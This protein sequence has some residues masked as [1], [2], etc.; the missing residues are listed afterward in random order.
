MSKHDATRPTT[1]ADIVAELRR[2]RRRLRVWLVVD[3]LAR[4]ALVTIAFFVCAAAADY[5]LGLPPFLRGGLVIAA[6][7][8]GFTWLRR[9]LL[10]P[11]FGTIGLDEIAVRLGA[12]RPRDA[13][14]LVSL[15]DWSERHAEG[16][17]ELWAL[18]EE[19]TLEEIQEKPLTGGLRV[20]GPL[21]RI[22]AAGVALT[23]VLV[24]QWMTP[25]WFST[26]YA[27]L[28]WPLGA[29]AWPSK[30]QIIPITGHTSIALGESIEATM[31][32]GRGASLRLRGYVVTQE[33]GKR[34]QRRLMRHDPDGDYRLTLDAVTGDI[35]YWFEAGDDDTRRT[36]FYIRVSERPHVTEAIA[37]VTPP[38]YLALS[39]TS[40]QP[41]YDAATRTGESRPW[42]PIKALE[43]SRVR[44]DIRA[45]KPVGVDAE[46]EPRAWLAFE[47]GALLPLKPTDAASSIF[48][49]SFE[50]E[51]SQRFEAVLVDTEG[52]RSTRGGS[53]QLIVEPDAPPSIAI[54]RPD[55]VVECTPIGRV[56]IAAEGRDDFGV[57]SMWLEARL[58]RAT[59]VSS[60]AHAEPAAARETVEEAGIWR[61]ELFSATESPA[62]DRRQV[63]GEVALEPALLAAQP[64]DVIEYI[65]GALDRS[66]RRE[67]TR[68][69][70][71]YVRVV[72]AEDLARRLESELANLSDLLRGLTTELEILREETSITQHRWTA[73]SSDSV[74]RLATAQQRL[75]DRSRLLAARLMERV[76]QAR[77]NRLDADAW[78][79]TDRLARGVAKAA[80]GP[81][82]EAAASLLR[83]AEHV[84]MSSPDEVGSSV[85]H[86]DEALAQLRQL[87]ADT[88]RWTDLEGVVRAARELLDR[89]ETL[90]RRTT[91]LGREHAGLS[92]SALSEAQASEL[93]R[94][95][96]EQEQ[97]ARQAKRLVEHLRERSHAADA[98][99]P[100]A[101]QAAARATAVAETGGVLEKM[102]TAAERIASNQPGRAVEMQQQAE[103]TLRDLIANLEEAP[104]RRLE[105]L[106]KELAD[107]ERRLQRLIEA[108]LK[109]IADNQKA[110]A[111]EARQQVWVRQAERQFSL[112][113]TT[114][115][116]ARRLDA[117][118]SGASEVRAEL[119]SAAVR[120]T[121]AAGRL[122]ESNGRQ[123]EPIQAEALNHITSAMEGL[124]D[125]ESQAQEEL[126]RRQMEQLAAALKRVHEAQQRLR[127][128]TRRAG[129]QGA[130]DLSP[131]GSGAGPVG[132]SRIARL[133]LIALAEEQTALV[134][135]VEDVKQRL[136]ASPV[137]GY[138]CQR[139]I[140]E[141]TRASEDLQAVQWM[142]AVNRQERILSGLH[143]LIE[144]LRQDHAPQQEP[145]FAEAGGG[146][147]G[148]TGTTESSAIPP[149]AE[150][151][152][153]RVLQSDLLE[154]AEK[155]SEAPDSS[156]IEHLGEQQ[157]ELHTLAERIFTAASEDDSEPPLQ[158]PSAPPSTGA[159]PGARM[160]DKENDYELA[161]RLL[162]GAP[163]APDA[164]SRLLTSMKEAEHRL[165]DRYD[166]GPETIAAQQRALAALDELIDQARRRESAMKNT[167]GK[168]RRASGS[169]ARPGGQRPT[170]EPQEAASDEEPGLAGPTTQPGRFDRRG[171]SDAAG[172][173]SR[174]W[175]FLPQR[176]RDELSAGLDEEYPGR[177][178]E[179]IER[180][181][182]SIA[183]E[184]AQP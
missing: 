35:T 140:T 49:G 10:R 177:Y 17:D 55:R 179:Y 113:T 90:T 43:G 61:R 101:V 89:Q 159:N 36:P 29:A 52:F 11:A 72:A 77:N 122:A 21:S 116:T 47:D 33:K 164:K 170:V 107:V 93:Q 149:L 119:N 76:E 161:R 130:A 165:L 20:R 75:L 96:Q 53:G 106:S 34:P 30:V 38:E 74:R 142:S 23:S 163:L 169:Q 168:K 121:R 139:V 9:G 111:D 63:R 160:D 12:R 65:A 50:A 132:L 22:A 59:Q 134:E 37:H 110:R 14:R 115:E 182:R 103:N 71:R 28:I 27:R 109:L 173:A 126:A 151:R 19:E 60:Q 94:T 105:A 104:V 6:L 124:R 100:F 70:A 112:R 54:L 155:I 32:V 174:G 171:V 98:D 102:T 45:S 16:M 137:G 117:A 26:A 84:S 79:R 180:Y 145:K 57:A 148:G 127:D 150:L 143:H 158:G 154:R 5:W 13:D 129:E 138:V 40:A 1:L 136:G 67:P 73:E 183:E 118:S 147:E 175:G 42:S 78:E 146:E 135:P 167:S 68:T 108:Q 48:S 131:R 128:E 162:H 3:G 2:V 24:C 133:R 69:S 58:N 25:D 31:R 88:D 7:I 176:D 178:R 114:G 91:R 144:T 184:A 80:E 18:V 86:Q 141:M 172:E 95:A 87:L 51:R 92:V 83:A 15:V 66:A 157:A 39:E 41:L 85:A 99:E 125:L 4:L 81:L 120:M 82:A 62:A 153:L 181:Y 97:A 8:F 166:A 64:G 156:A 44:I 152:L 123:A 46:G 56:E